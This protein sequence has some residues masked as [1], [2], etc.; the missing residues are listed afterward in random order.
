M[1]DNT[2]MARYWNEVAGPRWVQRQALQ[3]ARNVEM[4]EQLLAAARPAAGERVLDIGCG[5]G[6][7]TEPYANAVGPS[8]HVTAADISKPMLDAARQRIDSAGLRNVTLLLADAQIHEFPKASFDLL[9]S[10][11]G[12][13]FFADPTAA[14]R[15]LIEALRPGGRL[16]I[17]VWATVE[18]NLHQH[19]PLEVA[20]KHLGPP[21]AQSPHAPGPNAYG[22]RDY[23]RGI[24]D[25]AGFADIAI[26][27]RRFLV[28]ADTA[29]RA[30]E[31]SSQMGAVQR[32][33]DEKNAK[34]ATR[35][36]I[37]RDIEAAFRPYERDGATRIPATFLL[38]TARQ[39]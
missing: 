27:P 16:C 2:V 14:F 39:P 33:M 37:V 5:T 17:A 21:A 10:R 38:V 29:A 3:E 15:N 19:L 9:T 25:A 22:D 30:A 20:I 23:L 11:L 32:L 35:A 1:P 28:H 34:A 13:M 7:T 8:G 18:E 36:A 6:V 31:H 26:E 24:L 4:L 12:V